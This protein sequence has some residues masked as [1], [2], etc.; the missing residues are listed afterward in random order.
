MQVP[1]D[2]HQCGSQV[3]DLVLRLR[4]HVEEGHVDLGLLDELGYQVVDERGLHGLE[5]TTCLAVL[6]DKVGEFGPRCGG[7][8]V[9][10]VGSPRVVRRAERRLLMRVYSVT[11]TQ[12]RITRLLTSILSF[13]WARCDSFFGSGAALRNCVGRFE[14]GAR[15]MSASL[16]KS[17]TADFVDDI[18]RDRGGYATIQ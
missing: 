3:T 6:E 17:D 9:L 13:S 4:V 5:N 1:C 11:A 12:Q 2:L 10:G 18:L 8:V 15:L 16:S 7:G 14:D